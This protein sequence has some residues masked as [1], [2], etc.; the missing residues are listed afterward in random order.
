MKKR[1]KKIVS[2]IRN[3]GTFR[4]AA[5]VVGVHH[6]TAQRVVE[7]E[8]YI[9]VRSNDAKWGLCK[10]DDFTRNGWK[11]YNRLYKRNS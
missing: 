4:E 10:A 9:S 8:Y 3:G 7:R 1:D 2:V 5:E 11:I 6:R